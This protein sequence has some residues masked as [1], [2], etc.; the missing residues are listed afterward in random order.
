MII[1]DIILE[2]PTYLDSLLEYASY[3][4]E[5]VLE[6]LKYHEHHNQLTT[7]YIKFI[8]KHIQHINTNLK[9]DHITF[10]VIGIPRFLDNSKTNIYRPIIQL[11]TKSFIIEYFIGLFFNKFN[12]Y[13]YNHDYIQIEPTTQVFKVLSDSEFQYIIEI[14]QIVTAELTQHNNLK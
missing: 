13:N 3:Y 1:Q 2:Q 8:Q 12:I 14:L 4:K 7:E 6:F 10:S 5:E 11:K 9:K